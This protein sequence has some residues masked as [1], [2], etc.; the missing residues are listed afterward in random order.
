[1]SSRPTG[2]VRV[3]PR[4]G[5]SRPDAPE[6][7]R[8]AAPPR[9]WGALA[10]L[11][12]LLALCVVAGMWLWQQAGRTTETIVVAGDVRPGEMIERSDLASRPMA[13]TSGAFSVDDV[14]LVVG[15]RAR[16]GLVSGQVVPRAGITDM[17]VPGEGQRMVGL[18]LGP[19]RMPAD[20]EPGDLVSVIR[21]PVEGGEAA[22]ADL[23]RPA[24]LAPRAVV[25]SVA[26]TESGDAQLTISV[27]ESDAD[28]LAA[29]G[30]A[31]QVAVTQ[32]SVVP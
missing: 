25:S 2:A 18:E 11:V 14:S 23:A 3:A 4:A 16:V 19:A 32:V 22:Q 5:R 28:A 12:A 20:L 7:R 17:P 6:R 13:G 9:R 24:V 27:P 8:L 30:A 26:A 31:G 29:H 21:V 15:K 1:M 10:G